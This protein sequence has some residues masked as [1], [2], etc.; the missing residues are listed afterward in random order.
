MNC[1][2]NHIQCF[3]TDL[4][5]GFIV[6]HKSITGI[7]ECKQFSHSIQ[8][9]SFAAIRKGCSVYEIVSS[10]ITPG[11]LVFLAAAIQAAALLFRGQLRLRVLLLTGSIVY[12]FYYMVAAKEPLW[13]AMIATSAMSIAN[14]YGLAVLILGNTVRLIPANQIA[15]FSMFGEIQPGEFRLFMKLGQIRRLT[16][17]ETLTMIG[18]VPDYL[19]FVI[20]GEVE[21]EQGCG[22]FQIPSRHFIGEISLM[23]GTPASATT[24][25]KS[26][27]QIVQWPREQLIRNMARHPKMKTAVE[28]LLSRD[29]AR[30]VAVGAG[31]VDSKYVNVDPAV[32]VLF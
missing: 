9:G 16:D 18:K 14:I 4:C 22:R 29:M 15:L 13:E 10:Q 21:I 27:T 32:A 30:K 7:G 6:F 28:S 31:R 26:G 20:E 23:L 1:A 24:Q 19:Y 11:N 8:I 17:D 12:L 5:C 2:N 3:Q 25:V